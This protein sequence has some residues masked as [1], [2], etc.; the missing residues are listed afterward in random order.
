MQ[1]FTLSPSIRTRFR[2]P[3]LRCSYDQLRTFYVP[4]RLMCVVQAG[5]QQAAGVVGYPQFPFLN[6]FDADAAATIVAF[7][8]AVIHFAQ[9]NV[10]VHKATL[11]I[12]DCISPAARLG[13]DIYC[14]GRGVPKRSEYPPDMS[15]VFDDKNPDRWPLVQAYELKFLEDLRSAVSV[16][17]CE[18]VLQVVALI[19]LGNRPGELYTLA[20]FLSYVTRV[21]KFFTEINKDTLT[22]V[23]SKT[24]CAALIRNW[25][26]KFKHILRD[27][28]PQAG[29]TWDK[30]LQRFGEKVQQANNSQMLIA[31]LTSPTVTPDSVHKNKF[32]RISIP[33][34]N[35]NVQLE[36]ADL[37]NPANRLDT[38]GFQDIGPLNCRDCNAEYYFTAGEQAFYKSK[39]FE[40]MPKKCKSCRASAKAS[41][42]DTS[43]KGWN[44]VAPS[45]S[46]SSTSGGWGSGAVSAAGARP[47]RDHCTRTRRYL[48]PSPRPPPRSLLLRICTS[49]SI[50]P[51]RS[52][53]IW[54]RPG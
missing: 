21:A 16:D 3:R 7:C 13:L 51:A 36:S 2:F 37:P 11:V 12:T 31:G 6:Q 42:S 18:G 54:R 45:T 30:M 24:L 46:T 38:S 15:F 48:L 26:P 17:S 5:P 41:S 40:E 44:T 19:P 8:D 50:S 49:P 23:E 39:N 28:A 10:E 53:I 35:P 4:M 52:R 20:Q 25:P 43:G 22:K 1:C 27:S 33:F 47:G 14:R 34:P 9:T 32:R 29:E